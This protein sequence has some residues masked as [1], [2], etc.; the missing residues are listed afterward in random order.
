GAS[1]I[2]LVT[3]NT[4][5]CFGCVVSGEVD[6]DRRAPRLRGSESQPTP[7]ANTIHRHD[8]GRPRR[9]GVPSRA[10]DQGTGPDGR[11]QQGAGGWIP[12]LLNRRV[13]RDRQ[14]RFAVSGGDITKAVLKP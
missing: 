4:G 10:G 6:G 1:Q 12:L 7:A 3:G 14:R 2:S 13:C 11:S 8:A 5:S 9:S